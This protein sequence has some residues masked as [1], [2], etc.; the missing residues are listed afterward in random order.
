L[1]FIWIQYAINAGLWTGLVR[2]G[3]LDEVL[4]DSVNG[5]LSLRSVKEC[6]DV[7]AKRGVDLKK[8]PETK[9]FMNTGS[10]IGGMIVGF[11][12][13]ILFKFNKSVQRASAHALGDPRE[14]KTAYDNL[15]RTGTELDVDMSVMRSFQEDM[16]TFARKGY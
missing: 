3:G 7:V 12:M 4:R 1:H 13:R 6:L 11:A 16:E 15:M 8:H 10:K 14:I 9:M 2:A 5:P